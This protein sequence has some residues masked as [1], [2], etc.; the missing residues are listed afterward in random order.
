MTT[1]IPH[2]R[3]PVVY[4][5]IEVLFLLLAP[6]IAVVGFDISM[7]NQNTYVDP[8]LYTGYAHAFD[9]LFDRHGWTYYATRFGV[10]LPI[11]VASKAF[12]PIT[13]YY[14]LR[15]ILYFMV[16]V[17][18]YMVCRRYFGVIIAIVSSLFLLC[19][20]LL[21]RVMLW[22]YVAFGAVCYYMSGIC[23]WY[24]EFKPQWLRFMAVGFF[25][26]MAVSSNIFV[27]SAI[28][29]FLSVEIAFGLRRE[30]LSIEELPSMSVFVLSG[31]VLG[32]MLGIGFYLSVIGIHNPVKIVLGT[33]EVVRIVVA[34]RANYTLPL[35]E[36]ILGSYHCF[37]PF[38]LVGVFSALHGGRLTSNRVECRIALF[39]VVFLSFSLVYE[40]VFG[41]VCFELFYYFAYLVPMVLLLVPAV[42]YRVSLPVGKEARRNAV[43][44]SVFSFGVVLLGTALMH[45]HWNHWPSRL[46]AAMNGSVAALCVFLTFGV[47]LMFSLRFLKR[48]RWGLCLAA[49]SMSFL[50]QVA[51]FSHPRHAVLYG[52]SNRPPTGTPT[53]AETEHEAYQAAVEFAGFMAQYD[54]PDSR[55][56][57][58][59][60]RKD[61]TIFSIQFAYVFSSMQD[62]WTGAGLPEF[63]R[64]EVVRLR[65]PEVKYL[66]L[67]SQEDGDIEEGVMALE[68]NGVQ[69]RQQEE[70]R[71]GRQWVAIRS[72]LFEIINKRFPPQEKADIITPTPGSVLP[73]A[74]VTFQWN[75]SLASSYGIW[76]GRS[77]GAHDI[78]HTNCALKTS[79]TVTDLPVDGET[80]YV[81]LLSLVNGEWQ[82][83]DYSYTAF[84]GKHGK[85]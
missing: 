37:V 53:S 16:C 26:S 8:F 43:P 22:D 1:P 65:P 13:G 69:L 33:V 29:L 49:S 44:A 30:R 15:Y 71:F 19:N 5:G 6:V 50:L 61:V 7:I 81:R 62:V 46:Y 10:I 34:D 18:L 32:V 59:F 84:D 9:S 55:V 11:M 45:T 85:R 36:W 41:I 51:V 38:L 35:S 76:I 20:P 54:R 66:M 72:V 17:P 23:L 74:M 27:L 39:S 28:I 56:V 21:A 2:P 82:F 42:L 70:R 25:F 78:Y 14:V 3:T 79:A 47:I 12:G 60:P 24:M 64:F 77:P 63:G 58:W 52:K 75:D 83:S 67:M 57:T 31:G 80:I 40:F 73:S 48:S 68:S 4:R